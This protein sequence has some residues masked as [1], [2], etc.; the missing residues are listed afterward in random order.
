MLASKSKQKMKAV[1]R[2]NE[3]SRAEGDDVTSTTPPTTMTTSAKKPRVKLAPEVQER[4]D[5]LKKRM[6]KL[7]KKW[8]KAPAN[9][10]MKAQYRASQKAVFEFSKLLTSASDDNPVTAD[11]A[12]AVAAAAAAGAVARPKG[13]FAPHVFVRPSVVRFNVL[14]A[15]ACV[16]GAWS[17]R[18]RE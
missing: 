11:Q 7:K 3:E 8:L 12:A 18:Q 13:A 14:C 16:W 2:K 10:D 5:A 6:K 1:K 17:V 15:V 9:L 4:F